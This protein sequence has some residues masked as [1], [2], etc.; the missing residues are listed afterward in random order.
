MDAAAK[1]PNCL[2]YGVGWMKRG[3]LKDELAGACLLLLFSFGKQ[4]KVDRVSYLLVAFVPWMEVI[5]AI[6]IR[7]KAR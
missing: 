2:P 6:H 1:L 4:L 3:Q 7:R 5:A